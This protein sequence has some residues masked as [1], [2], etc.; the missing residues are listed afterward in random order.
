ME[1]LIISH[2]ASWCYDN[3]VAIM[4]LPLPNAHDISYA[5]EAWMNTLLDFFST[6]GGGEDAPSYAEY[7]RSVGITAYD[8]DKELANF[9]EE[10]RWE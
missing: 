3:Y 4:N 7:M 1:K 10:S 5:I 9:Y 8:D 2:A 6:N